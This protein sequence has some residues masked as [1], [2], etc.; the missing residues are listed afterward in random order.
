MSSI[1]GK[2]WRCLPKWVSLSSIEIFYSWSLEKGKEQIVT[3]LD[4]HTI[5]LIARIYL[6]NCAKKYLPFNLSGSEVKTQ[7]GKKWDPQRIIKSVRNVGWVQK[8]RQKDRVSLNFGV[9][10][11][12]HYKSDNFLC[13]T[14]ICSLN[15]RAIFYCGYLGKKKSDGN[16]DFF[17][18]NAEFMI[19]WSTFIWDHGGFFMQSSRI[20][21]TYHRRK[22]LKN[23]KNGK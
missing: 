8:K 2:Q 1:S 16:R 6:Q 18:E 5:L 21:G 22:N 17:T 19:T 20:N 3:W 23:H 4:L 13:K 10:R 11:D 15:P 7:E 9:H 12:H 14:E